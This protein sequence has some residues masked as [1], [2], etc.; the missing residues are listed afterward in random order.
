M[1]IVLHGL[2]KPVTDRQ[3]M[4]TLLDCILPFLLFIVKCLTNIKNWSK[5]ILTISNEWDPALQRRRSTYLNNINHIYSYDERVLYKSIMTIE[6]LV[7]AIKDADKNGEYKTE[8]STIET[9]II[10]LTNLANEIRS[11]W[12]G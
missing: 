8:I 10:P 3:R 1:Y 9:Q 7:E 12:R 5:N 11:I 2:I 4:I 6:S